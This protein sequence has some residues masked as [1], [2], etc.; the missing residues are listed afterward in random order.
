MHMEEF[1]EKEGVTGGLRSVLPPDNSSLAWGDKLWRYLTK[2]GNFVNFVLF[3]YV[4]FSI[5]SCSVR[6]IFLR[7]CCA[8]AIS[9]TLTRLCFLYHV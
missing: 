9:S 3:V 4:L 5:M 6:D 8:H 2:V 1:L 7:L